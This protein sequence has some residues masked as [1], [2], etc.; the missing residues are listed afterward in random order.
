MSNGMQY[1]RTDK[2]IQ[3]AFIRL[4]KGN[5]F[6]RI[7][8]QNILDEAMI[9]RNTFYQHYHDKYE[10]AERIY[11]GSLSRTQKLLDDLYVYEASRLYQLDDEKREEEV[12]QRFLKFQQENA[13]YQKV[14]R[15]LPVEGAALKDIF[16]ERHKK[17]YT[18]LMEVP[19]TPPKQ[20]ALES[21]IYAGIINSLSEYYEH[22]THS[23]SHL[24]ETTNQAILKAAL[25]A[26]GVRK[27]E[28]QTDLIRQI[29]VL[30]KQTMLDTKAPS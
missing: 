21:A 6:E 12:R 22:E 9:S 20:I 5:S 16:F 18:Q 10:L 17:R 26:V 3:D 28:Y 29:E 19:D 4:L 2:N 8:V 1:Q 14:L 24:N 30:R 25:F 7:T 27:E 23:Q 13:E 15:K 11:E